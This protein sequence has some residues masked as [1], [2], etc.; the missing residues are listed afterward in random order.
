MIIKYATANV[1]TK[2]MY[3]QPNITPIKNLV[4]Y[5]NYYGRMWPFPKLIPRVSMELSGGSLLVILLFAWKSLDCRRDSGHPSH[6]LLEFISI[7]IIFRLILSFN[8]LL[9]MK[10]VLT[11]SPSKLSFMGLL[12]ISHSRRC[13]QL[14]P[15]KPNLNIIHSMYCRN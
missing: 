7:Q 8:E 1:L 2:H 13:T 4:K 5:E 10:T 9:Y 14:S 11:I 15:S 3:Y 6:M 12:L